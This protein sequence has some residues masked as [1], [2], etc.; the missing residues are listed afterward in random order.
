[1]NRVG[2][3]IFAVVFVGGLSLEAA[4]PSL[5]PLSFESALTK[6][7]TAN[8]RVLAAQSGVERAGAEVGVAKGRRWPEVNLGARH[9][10]I[11]QPIVI[12]LDPI[13]Q[14]MLALHPSVPPAALPPFQSRV[15]DDRFS[16]VTVNA[17]LPLFAGGRIEAGVRASRAGLDSAIQQRRGVEGEVSADLAR[18]YFGLRLAT[19]NRLTRQGIRDSIRLHVDRAS[20]LERNGQIARAER[21]RAEV[22]LAEANRELDQ[23]ARDEQ[24]ARLALSN[25]L[26]SDEPVS[27]TTPLFRVADLPPLE[28]FSSRAAQTNPGLGRLTAEHQRA[29]EG[30]VAARGESYPSLGLFAMREIY[31]KDL[32]LL[33]PT[34][35]VGIALN[36]PIFQGGQRVQR[37]NAARSQERQV[38]YLLQRARRDVTLL[39]EQ[40]YRQVEEAR[41]Q[42]ASLQTTQALAEESLRAQQLA[43]GA[44]LATSLDVTDA[45]QALARVRLG[46]LKAMYEGDVA[47]AGLLEATGQSERLPEFI[48][49]QTEVGR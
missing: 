33:Q 2:Y 27:A 4:E 25:I 28:S 41:G 10:F 46:I 49:A 35:A 14:A 12:D 42:L 38:G 39:I 36:I 24:L 7:R 29:R 47:L 43:F 15:Q 13:R 6:A 5:I 8:E 17:T 1:M 48:S 34:W 31:T 18:R 30:V 19:E 44:G 23:A 3:V 45:E 32:T 9:T 22:A 20:S 11:D 26:A 21:L 37:V 16:N 40:R